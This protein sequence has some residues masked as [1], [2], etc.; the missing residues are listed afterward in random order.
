MGHGTV[1]ESQGSPFSSPTS[2][3]GLARRV[4][5][6]G[7]SPAEAKAG[8]GNGAALTVVQFIYLERWRDLIARGKFSLLLSTSS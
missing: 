8:S 4:N 5:S 7:A 6:A 3:R 2:Q 1:R